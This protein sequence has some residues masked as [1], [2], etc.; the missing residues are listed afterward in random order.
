[1]ANVPGT[2]VPAI[3]FDV[4]RG[5]VAP[6]GPDV[7]AGVQADINAAFGKN[8]NYT[9]TTPQGQIA[10][11]EAALIVNFNSLLVFYSNMTNPDFAF[12]RMQDAIANIYFLTR[13]PAQPTVLQCPCLGLPGTVIAVDSL[14]VDTSGNTYTCTT[15]GTIPAGGSITLPFANLVAGPI[16]APASDQ[17]S[18]YQAIPGWDSVSVASSVLGVDVEN[19]T[20]FEQR[21]RDSVAGNSLGAIGSIIG[22]VAKVPGV[23]DFF[24]YDNAT[25]APVTVF[26]VS[27][28]ANS[29]YVS[30]SGGTDDAVAQA[31]ISKKAPGCSYS[32]TVNTTVNT[33]DSNP[34][35]AAPIP[36]TVKFER[37]ADLPILYSVVIVNGPTV[38]ADAVAQVQNA[39]IAAAAG[40]DGG[41]RARIASTIL[42][43]R[44]VYPIALL[45]PWAQISSLQVG[46]LNT[47][48]SSFTGV[49]AGTTLTTSAVSGA[50]A[51]GQF[52]SDVA[53]GI[54]AGT[55]II[56][57]SGSSWQVSISQTVSSRAMKGSTAN[58]S[59]V[60]VRADQEPLVEAAYIKVALT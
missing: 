13:N 8:L 32:S 7:L 37:P 52:L 23:V 42:A 46:S 16:P 6:G 15:E 5:F 9:L 18:I 31:I 44:Y 55:T 40:E 4:S 54:A 22:A 57:G 49:I 41:V 45:G 2:N 28:D 47:Q 25:N 59:Q 38:P 3:S 11:S 53:G 10:S 19:R 20:A 14:A 21:R 48:T 26:G 24:G 58:Q 30:V 27:V 17:L 56:S 51:I 29:I 36:Y 50:V 60:V 33:F 43:S 34:L 35:Y 1:M 12:G 39:V